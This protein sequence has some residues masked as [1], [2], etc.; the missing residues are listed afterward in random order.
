MTGY[1]FVLAANFFWGLNFVFAKV[2]STSVPPVALAFWR[3]TVAA[4]ILAPFLPAV[5]RHRQVVREHWRFYLSAALSGIVLYHVCVYI[6]A[7][8]SS[9]YALP[10]ITAFSGV[11]VKAAYFVMGRG[12]TAVQAAGGTLAAVGLAVLLGRGELEVL[13]GLEFVLG[14]LWLLLGSFL[15]AGYSLVLEHKPKWGTPNTGNLAAI[16]CGLPFL[17]LL[18]GIEASFSGPFE[19]DARVALVFLYLGLF[20]SVV[21]YWC[22]LSAIDRIGA[23]RSHAM[24]YTFPLFTAA[25]AWL[26]LD[27]SL[28]WHHAVAAAAIIAGAVLTTL[29]GRERP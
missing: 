10:L 25:Q 15:W 23:V 20:P 8:T 11:I 7:H 19:V 16:L 18:Y 27:E 3:W 13:L 26:I 6:G 24:Y 21:S 1:L 29:G 4:L 9:I 5:W 2:M 22:W 17:G 14:D 12:L 28:H